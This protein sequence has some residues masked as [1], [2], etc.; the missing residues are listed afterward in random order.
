MRGG[1]FMRPRRVAHLLVLVG[2]I[3]LA[4]GAAQAAF[5][6]YA[7]IVAPTQLQT[8]ESRPVEIVVQ[9]KPGA[10]PDTFRAWLNGRLI[11][12][13]FVATPTGVTASVDV[14]DGL[15]VGLETDP[16]LAT[17]NVLATLVKGPGRKQD[18]DLQVFF[19]RERSVS[20]PQLV[21]LS[22]EAAGAALA[23]AGL[24]AG[25]VSDVVRVSIPTGIVIEQNPVSGT[26]APR[27]SA[28]ALVRV[29][30]PPHD[31]AIPD[32]WMGSWNLEFTYRDTATGFIDSVMPV[33]NPICSADPIG[34]AALEAT[35][36]ANPAA[37]LTTC[38]ATATED[39]IDISCTGEFEQ[40]FCAVPV[41]ARISLVRSGEFIS[42]DGEW[43]V[44]EPCG[45]PL[46]SRGQTIEI[47][48]MRASTDPG[49]ACAGPPSSLLQKFIRNSLLVL[50]RGEL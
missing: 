9:F 2:S 7:T 39:R 15:R 41:T 12:S 17:L 46:Q 50:L 26:L 38:T 29:A 21:G 42:G 44:G 11:T 24:T 4:P 40:I 49:A 36:A 32:S 35:A 10:R 48:G 22:T 6:D 43:S 34:V 5:W 23:A 16:P 31:I 20:V 13:R 14:G 33:S 30:Q 1:A 25:A 45:I 27:G 37:G 47:I 28:V 8:L 18:G 19:V 3:L